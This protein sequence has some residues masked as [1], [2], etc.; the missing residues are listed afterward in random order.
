[1]S[2]SAEE[3]AD[4]E[5]RPSFGE[6]LGPSR[7]GAELTVS[8]HEQRF[9]QIDLSGKFENWTCLRLAAGRFAVMAANLETLRQ[10]ISGE[11]S[12]ENPT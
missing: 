1:V 8:R 7:D 9:A 5:W 3:L 11:S 4:N 12:I 6:E 2:W 10:M